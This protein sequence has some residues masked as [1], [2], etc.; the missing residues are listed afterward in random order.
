MSS[1][2]TRDLVGL[3]VSGFEGPRLSCLVCK[4]CLLKESMYNRGFG[5]PEKCA[6]HVMRPW[7]LRGAVKAVW[8]WAWRA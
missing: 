8:V 1:E 2:G 6:R 7:G 4:L 3:P 5:L